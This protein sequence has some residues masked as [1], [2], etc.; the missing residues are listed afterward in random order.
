M[1]MEELMYFNGFGGFSQDGKEYCIRVTKTDR[2][3][4]PWSHLLV[5]SKIGTLVTSNGGGF[6]WYGNSRENKISTWCNDVILDT[7]SEKI[8][9]EEEKEQ[10][11][12]LSDYI[13]EKEA[14]EIIYGFG[15]ATYRLQSERYEQETTIFVTENPAQ[16]MSI[17]KIKNKQQEAK[18]IK[19]K[20]MIDAVLGVAKEYTEK[21]LVSSMEKDF[22]KLYNRYSNDYAEYQVFLKIL[23]FGKEEIR[24]C[25][26]LEKN[27]VGI[28][29]EILLE[30]G[31]ERELV[32]VLQ[33]SSKEEDIKNDSLTECREF[34]ELEKNTWKQKLQKVQVTT[35]VD[36]MNIILNGWILYQTLTS[37]IWGRSSFYQSGGAY[38]FRDQL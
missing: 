37:R 10:W 13:L 4:V 14:F 35:P 20:F 5:N 16:K 34:L 12:A 18:K 25:K 7:A 28:E 9:L 23:T 29:T 31:E 19:I 8:W 27:Y 17:L 1:R 2:T 36:S 3:P 6:S 24:E 30:A 22:L 33:Y 21:H 32:M 11:S 15:Y 26:N 38:W